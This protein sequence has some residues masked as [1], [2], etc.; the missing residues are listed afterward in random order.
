MMMKKISK[1]VLLAATI[2]MLCSTLIPHHHHDNV[3]CLADDLGQTTEA[4]SSGNNKS[5]EDSDECPLDIH[6][7]VKAFHNPVSEIRFASQPEAI[8]VSVMEVPE[9]T[10]IPGQFCLNNP[11]TSL[12]PGTII[13]HKPLRAPPIA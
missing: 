8:L 2:M 11:Q 12:F 5:D 1:T 7:I 4:E 9:T 13:R 3:I 6:H 10:E